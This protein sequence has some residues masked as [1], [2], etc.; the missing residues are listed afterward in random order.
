[1]PRCLVNV[2][3]V[4]ILAIGNWPAPALITSVHQKLQSTIMGAV[5]NEGNNNIGVVVQPVW[6]STKGQVFD[7]NS[8]LLKLMENNN[9]VLDLNWSMLFDNK[10]D[11]RG[12][13]P[14]NYPG[15]FCLGKT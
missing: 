6:A 15:R 9:V 12:E 10:C 4:S 13:R 5:V 11:V 8:T 2:D 3:A 1:M 7:T 14:L